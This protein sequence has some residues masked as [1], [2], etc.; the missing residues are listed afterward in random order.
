MTS[1]AVGSTGSSGA[2][3][4]SWC[5]RWYQG[6][7][8]VESLGGNLT[9]APTLTTRGP[10]RLDVFA[11][12]LTSNG[13]DHT[14]YQLGWWS[15][16]DE[17]SGMSRKL[18]LRCRRRR[19][20][21]ARRPQESRAAGARRPLSAEVGEIAATSA[22]KPVPPPGRGQTAPRVSSFS[23]GRGELPLRSQTGAEPGG[24]QH[25]GSP[26]HSGPK[27]GKCLP[28][29]LS[30]RS[31]GSRL[32]RLNGH[33][34]RRT[35]AVRISVRDR[36]IRTSCR[37]SGVRASTTAPHHEEPDMHFSRIIPGVA[38]IAGARWTGL[39][40]G[41]YLRRDLSDR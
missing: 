19:R 16:A 8:S 36:F 6:G 3:T 30:K 20:A 1:W 11:R 40:A 26:R 18:R 38:L 29:P 33:T 39:P 24:S 4:T 14:S 32:S 9:S 15:W 27:R 5:T 28:V 23:A 25:P 37:G 12:D 35:R 34:R 13:I 17:G 41:C 7:W 31:E 21:A 2:R 22:H 10:G